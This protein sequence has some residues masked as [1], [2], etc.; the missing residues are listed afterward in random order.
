MEKKPGNSAQTC[1]S[2]PT[3]TSEWPVRLASDHGTKKKRKQTLW[4]TADLALDGIQTCYSQ[5]NTPGGH[6]SGACL[7]VWKLSSLYCISPSLFILLTVLI[8]HNERGGD[9]GKK[10]QRAACSSLYLPPSLTPSR[11]SHETAAA[12]GRAVLSTCKALCLSSAGRWNKKREEEQREQSFSCCI[13]KYIQA[14]CWRTSLC[15]WASV[16]RTRAAWTPWHSTATHAACR[17]PNYCQC[18]GEILTQIIRLPTKLL[19]KTTGGG[20]VL[21]HWAW[22]FGSCLRVKLFSAASVLK[23]RT[24]TEAWYVSYSRSRYSFTISGCLVAKC[25]DGGLRHM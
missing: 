24:C 6:W 3:V 23:R 22:T 25:A 19:P 2:S 13:S 5:E 8:E 4:L 10:A 11:T 9:K 21:A 15:Q 18:D 12:C 20:G 1:V 17:K 14:L 16:H 7:P